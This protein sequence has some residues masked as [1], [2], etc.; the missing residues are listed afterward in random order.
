[1]SG[2]FDL[3]SV[4]K[5][6]ENDCTNF[7][8]SY[9]SGFWVI[10]DFWPIFATFIILSITINK[11][12]L[13]S[14]VVLKGGALNILINWAAREIIRQYGPEPNCSSDWQMPAYA[15]DS[16]A[17]LTTTLLGASGFIYDVP[18]SM[19]NSTV[20]WVGVPVALYARIWLRFN[21]GPQLLAGAAFGVVEGI[22][23]CLVMRYILR[24]KRLRRWFL[25]GKKFFISSC[26]DTLINS[27]FPFVYLAYSPK[28]MILKLEASSDD[29]YVDMPTEEIS[30]R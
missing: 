30:G 14:L 29:K 10:A 4:G 25:R 3:S 12:E 8:N 17:F 22:I 6:Y 19:F 21:T 23:Y 24:Y 2:W 13:F 1:M 11:V 27:R 20:L 15:S 7:D 9:V 28:E 5:T 16:L 18:I 26:Q